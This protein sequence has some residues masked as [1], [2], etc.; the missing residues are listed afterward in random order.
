[1]SEIMLALLRNVM[2]SPLQ[3]C[4]RSR[5]YAHTRRRPDGSQPRALCAAASAARL[6]LPL[7][8]R[9]CAPAAYVGA[10]LESQQ[11]GAPAEGP[12][13]GESGPKVY[14]STL[15]VPVGRSNQDVDERPGSF[16]SV[17]RQ[18]EIPRLDPTRLDVMSNTTLPTD[19]AYI[20]APPGNS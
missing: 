14:S 1:M 17:A 10:G 11:Y 7:K 4:S 18:D 13:A 5:L 6:K 20:F 9:S 19:P 8:S 15:P 2:S 3:L 12:H 16:R